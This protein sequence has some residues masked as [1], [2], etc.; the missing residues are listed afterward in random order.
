MRNADL[1][2]Y[3]SERRVF[4]ILNA[5]SA[6]SALRAA[7]AAIVGGIKLLEVELTTPGAYRVISEL[8]HQYGDRVF[9]GSGSVLNRDHIDRSIKC[10]SGF[11]SSPHT[12]T[13]L[14]EFCQAKAIPILTGGATPTEI[15]AAWSMGVPVVSIFPVSLLGGTSYLQALT[16]RMPE[17]RLRP[18]GGVLASEISKYFAAGAFSVA[19]GSDLFRAGDV[20][21]ENYSAIAERA[22]SVMRQAG[23]I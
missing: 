2:S 17:L 3:I 11:V 10:G 7:E 13:S 8:R 5:E 15:A 16:K 20:Q 21:T 6:E 9:I 19:I 22:R 23:A 12:S 1:I 14:I 18:Y 4:A